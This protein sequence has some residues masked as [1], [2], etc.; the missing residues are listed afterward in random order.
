MTIQK[1]VEKKAAEARKGREK[2]LYLKETY[3]I[4][5]NTYIILFPEEKTQCNQYILKYLPE[6]SKKVNANRIILLSYDEEILKANIHCSDIVYEIVFWNRAAADELMAYYSIQRFS[7]N[8]LIAS[9]NQPKGRNGENLIGINGIT[10][11]E[12]VSI[13]ILGIRGVNKND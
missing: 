1:E 10:E 6:F 5:K 3:R 7:D 4:D 9:L 8:L 2:W 11:E 12:V 13:G